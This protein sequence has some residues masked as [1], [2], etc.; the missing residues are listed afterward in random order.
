MSTSTLV[1]GKLLD[2][3][4]PARALMAA[5]GLVALVPIAFWRSQEAAFQSTGNA[6]EG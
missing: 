5:C 3:G 6:A 1:V 4:V 2:Q